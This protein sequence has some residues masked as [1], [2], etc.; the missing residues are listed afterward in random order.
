MALLENKRVANQALTAAHNPPTINKMPAAQ[1]ISNQ[2]PQINRNKAAVKIG[3]VRHQA[4]EATIR[5][6]KA[7]VVITINNQAAQVNKMGTKTGEVTTKTRGDPV[8]VAV[9]INNQEHQTNNN[10]VEA[11]ANNQGLQ[12][13]KPT[14]IK[15]DLILINKALQ[16]ATINNQKVLHPISRVPT[17][18][19]SNQELINKL[20]KAVA[21]SQVAQALVVIRTKEH[22]INKALPAATTNKLVE[23]VSNQEHHHQVNKALVTTI[24]SQVEVILCLVNKDHPVAAIIKISSPGLLQINKTLAPTITNRLVAKALPVLINNK[25]LQVPTIKVSLLQLLPVLTSP[26][27]VQTNNKVEE[28]KHHLENSTKLNL[29]KY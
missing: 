16:A 20:E 27:Q 9:T 23:V 29:V 14:K 17:A 13:V 1:T 18:T 28:T 6:S 21:N 2:G 8:P 5:I 4:Q 3:E 26:D 12:Q 19:I 22:P 24:S 7:P 11:V 25:L 15:G 10:K